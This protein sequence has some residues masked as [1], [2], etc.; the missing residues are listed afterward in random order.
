M[1]AYGAGVHF[2][3]NFGIIL[4]CSNNPNMVFFLTRVRQR[5]DEKYFTVFEPL[6]EEELCDF[7]ELPKSFNRL[8][9]KGDKIED[10]N[11]RELFY[12]DYITRYK[13]AR[14]KG[15][16]VQQLSDEIELVQKMRTLQEKKASVEPERNV[17]TPKSGTNKVKTV[18][19]YELLKLIGKGK[20]QNDLSKISRLAAYMFSSTESN[21]YNDAQPGIRL[22]KYHQKEIEKLN[23]LLKDLDIPIE[24]K[25]DIEY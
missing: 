6:L 9:S 13:Q 3:G 15:N 1:G 14:N 24:I 11:E 4:T 12:T 23:S 22:T 25:K 16:I 2:A 19:L 18:L 20:S 5:V 10:L 7:P 8:K 17:D 21:I